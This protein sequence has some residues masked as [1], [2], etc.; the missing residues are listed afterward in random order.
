MFLEI[1]RGIDPIVKLCGDWLSEINVYS[2]IIRLL[3]AILFAGIIG[4]ERATKNHAA[5]FRTYILVCLGATIAMM[6]NQFM[7]E[8]TEK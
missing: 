5:G 7:M 6:T 4:V 8:S 1:N 2:I 3:F